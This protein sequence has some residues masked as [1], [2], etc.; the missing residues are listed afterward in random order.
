MNISF[1]SFRC[2]YKSIPREQNAM[3]NANVEIWLFEI[4]RFHQNCLYNNIF[5]VHFGTRLHHD[6]L[7]VIYDRLKLLTGKSQFLVLSMCE[8]AQ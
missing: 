3:A 6:R 5:P 8:K 4:C 2:F 1:P 7:F